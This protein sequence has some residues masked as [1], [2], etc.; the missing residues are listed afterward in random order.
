MLNQL[1]LATAMVVAIVVIHLS[2]LAILTRLLRSHSRVMRSVRI[3]PITLLAGATMGII[4]IHTFE[5]WLYA[6][7]YLG[8]GAF[9]HFEDALYFSTST[10]ATIGYGDLLLPHQWRVFGVI[11]GPAG[12]IMLG[13]STAYLVSLLARMKLLSHDWLTLDEGER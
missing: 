4:A 1:I 8:L 7:A 13:L 12:V 2:S 5:I 3:M 10:Y 6:A 9:R 11:E